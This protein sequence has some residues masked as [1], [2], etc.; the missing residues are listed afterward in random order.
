LYLWRI[1]DLAQSD[2][3]GIQDAKPVKRSQS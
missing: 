3:K 2:A 1:A